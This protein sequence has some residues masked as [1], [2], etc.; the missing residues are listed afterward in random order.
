MPATS[1]GVIQ[2]RFARSMVA[3]L[4]DVGR[5]RNSRSGQ[6][7]ESLRTDTAVLN[8]PEVF[9]LVHPVERSSERR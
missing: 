8:Q 5:S 7:P 2:V 1:N 9:R 4:H 6:R 3:G